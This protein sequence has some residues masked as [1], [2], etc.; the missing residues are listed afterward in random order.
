MIC[1]F[2]FASMVYHTDQFVYIEEYL[3]PWD[4]PHLI[5]VY[6]TFNVSLN[7]IC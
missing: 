7:S 3:H 5:I 2:Q 6:D 4:K 1:I